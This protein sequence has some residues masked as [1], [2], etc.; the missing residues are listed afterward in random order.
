MRGAPGPGTPLT[1]VLSVVKY[2]LCTKPANRP[3]TP[4]PG[5]PDQH[6]VLGEPSPG[7]GTVPA[8]IP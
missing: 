8:T 7:C 4:D 3:M 5:T 6:W 2:Q 1:L